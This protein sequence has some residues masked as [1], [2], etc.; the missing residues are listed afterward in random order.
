MALRLAVETTS[1]VLARAPADCARWLSVSEQ[2]RLERLRVEPRRAQY[3]AGHWLAREL[4]V[5]EAGGGIAAWTLEARPDLP[6]AILG[7]VADLHLSLSHSGDFIAAAVADAAIGIDIEQRRPREALHRF[8]TLLLAEGEFPGTLDNDALLL[9]WVVKEAWIKRGHGSALPERLAALRIEPV[10]P[11]SADVHT[12]STADLHLGLA[13]RLLPV[14]S[15]PPLLPVESAMG[16]R[17]R[18]DGRILAGT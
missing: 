12:Y 18:R 5:A 11:A 8:D 13:A 2:A 16:W 17:V 15:I 4:L 10:A 6:P 1:A 3:L 9:R 14:H 7:P